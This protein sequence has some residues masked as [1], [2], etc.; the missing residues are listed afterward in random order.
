M[1]LIPAILPKGYVSIG[2]KRLHEKET[3]S[4]FIP[5]REMFLSASSGELI[6]RIRCHILVCAVHR[7]LVVAVYGSRYSDRC[8]KLTTDHRHLRRI[9]EHCRQNLDGQHWPHVIFTDESRI[10]I[11]HFGFI[12]LGCDNAIAFQMHDETFGNC[13]HI[14]R[15]GWPWAHQQIWDEISVD[16]S[17]RMRVC[18]H[19]AA[20]TII[21]A[22][23]H[24]AVRRLT[25]RSREV[26]KPRDSG[27]NFSNRS[28]I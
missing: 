18:K 10:S 17:S 9:L 5:W 25:T 24:L 23:I 19:A 21:R 2:W 20:L 22:S 15:G 8:P 13:H 27:L 6:S 1:F 28:E 12:F 16:G 4:F 14:S 11:Y 7:R 26:S 3:M